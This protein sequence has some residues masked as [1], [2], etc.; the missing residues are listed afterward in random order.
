MNRQILEQ[1]FDDKFIKQRKGNYG[2]M[3]DYIET[4]VV[5]Q[6]LNDAF[7]GQWNFEVMEYQHMNDEVVVLGKLTADGV[8]KMQFGNSKVSISKS[9]EVISI[10]DDIKSA[11][12]DALKKTAT[13]LGVGL[14]LYGQLP[15]TDSDANSNDA[16]D[17]STMSGNKG[18]NLISNEQLATI[19]KL[20][21]KLKWNAS[22][23]QDKSER[24]FATRDIATLNSTMATALISYLQ[25]RGNGNGDS[26]RK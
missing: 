11:A 16:T 25:N 20:R 2:K 13:L 26:K 24:L 14:H 18:T 5:I 6:R 21:M 3:L 22:D 19:K 23:V 10:G 9:G 17:M 4:H 1:P 12:S 7:D 15:E 8:V